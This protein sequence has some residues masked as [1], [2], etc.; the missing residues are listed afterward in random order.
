MYTSESGMLVYSSLI[1]DN[2]QVN[3]I[4]L[5]DA[6]V[7]LALH[8]FILKLANLQKDIAWNSD[9]HNLHKIHRATTYIVEK[10]HLPSQ[11][12]HIL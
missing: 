10:V 5:P 4:S 12:S 2:T 8:A 7:C 9:K 6:Q 3:L 11:L 1:T